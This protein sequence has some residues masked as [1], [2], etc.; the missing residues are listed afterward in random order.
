M[1]TESALTRRSLLGPL[2]LVICLAAALGFAGSAS[3]ESHCVGSHPLCA[4]PNQY[5]AD[6]TGLQTAL[7]AAN[8]NSTFPGADIVY[9]E[10]GTI[11]VPST[12]QIGS[13][14][15]PLEVIGEGVGSTFLEAGAN[16]VTVLQLSNPSLYSVTVSGLTSRI[17]GYG[18]GVALGGTNVNF[19]DIEVEAVATTGSV[20]GIYVNGTSSISNSKLTL[21]GSSVTGVYTDDSITIQDSQIES[22][23]GQSYAMN[24]SSNGDTRTVERTTFRNLR[25]AVNM[26]SGSLVVRDSFILLSTV[27][28][29]AGLL[30]EN[31]NNC[32][33]CVIDLLVENVTIVGTGNNAVGISTGATG[34]DGIFETGSAVIRNTLVHLTG[35]GSTV[36]LR[37]SQSGDST[38]AS[39]NTSYVAANTAKISR[40][41]T[42]AGTDSNQLDTTSAPPTF[43]FPTVGD[44]R[45]NTGSPVIDAGDPAEVV[46]LGDQDVDGD[47]RLFDG[48]NDTTATIDIGAHEFQSAQAPSNA[49][50]TATPDPANVNQTINFTALAVEP[51]GG[52]V[53]YEWNFGDATTATGSN[54]THAYTGPGDFTVSVVATDN[55]GE[56]STTTKVVHVTSDPPTAPTTVVS[57][58]PTAYRGDDITF[59]AS[60]ATDANNDDIHY[61]WSFTGGGQ[62]NS[63]ESIGVVRQATNMVNGAGPT[64]YEAEVRAVDEYNEESAPVQVSPAVVIYNRMPTVTSI[65]KSSNTAYRG[66]NITFNMVIADAENDPIQASWNLDDGLGALPYDNEYQYD[67]SYSTVG[68]KTISVSARDSYYQQAGPGEVED[69]GSTTV[70]ILN[71][72]PVVSAIQHSGSLLTSDPQT[73][74]I[75]ATESEGDAVSYKWDFGD[76][77][78]AAASSQGSALKTYTTPGT[79]TV[80]STVMD[81]QG[82]AVISQRSVTVAGRQAVLKIG[83]PTKSFW[84][85]NKGFALGAKSPLPYIPITS[86]EPVELRITM[87]RVKGGYLKGKSCV[88]RKVGKKRCTLKLKG[89]QRLDLVETNSKVA[90]GA[91][92]AGKKLAPGK[93]KVTFTPQDGGPAKS[94]NIKILKSKPKKK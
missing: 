93:Y 51:D 37:C 62:A 39:M 34:S 40:T 63:L 85:R 14:S 86:T 54:P 29:S 46:D 33:A 16:N 87:A 75:S 38:T 64:T 59:T 57:D 17:I 25:R 90:F 91:K 50:L 31:L 76:G 78:G 48:D 68:T 13:A 35:T 5:S 71:R 19:N 43:T 21:T 66:D 23:D 36:A 22:T 88:K 83:R 44:Y 72:D 4:G 32:T 3:A 73:F 53:S 47:D 28:N 56:E 18:S 41:G 24:S 80:T 92:W 79:Y 9:I 10:A 7:N 45:P 8:N 89:V 69:T 49:E 6:A 67:R 15:G 94:T 60:G 1:Q 74:S 42:C 82:A 11:S 58:V 52:A 84:P 55:E 20:R 65:T 26:D 77:T 2:F 27:S 81:D 30:A 61:E 12:I 70:Q